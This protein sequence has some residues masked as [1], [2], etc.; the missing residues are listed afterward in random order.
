[1]DSNDDTI[2][3]KIY[4]PFLM[5]LRSQFIMVGWVEVCGQRAINSD[6]LIDETHTIRLDQ[7]LAKY[8]N[9]ITILLSKALKYAC[10][11]FPKFIL[12]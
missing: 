2:F 8:G 5:Y 12:L 1:M 4:V 9:F 7:N 3:L 10:T 11:G 6:L